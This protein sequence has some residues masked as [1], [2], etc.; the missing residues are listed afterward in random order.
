MMIT[1]EMLA[2]GYKVMIGQIQI[3]G[4]QDFDTVSKEATML[5]LAPTRVDSLSVQGKIEMGKV[6]L[7][8]ATVRYR[9]RIVKDR[10]KT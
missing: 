10:S 9:G 5:M 1:S 7:S 4:V 2:Q 6:I 3:A 8:E